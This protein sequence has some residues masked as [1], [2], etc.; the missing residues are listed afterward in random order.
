MARHIFQACLVWIYTQSIT[1]ILLTWVHFTPTQKIS[2][3]LDYIDIEGT[4][5]RY[6]ISH[7]RTELTA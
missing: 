1:S 7:T 4:R 3:L 5:L 6:E 2:W